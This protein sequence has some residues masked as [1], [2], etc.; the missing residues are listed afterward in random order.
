[1]AWLGLALT[2]AAASPHSSRRTGAESVL[3]LHFLGDPRGQ[4]DSRQGF[5]AALNLAYSAVH[6]Y[7]Y[8][9]VSCGDSI[10]CVVK[11]MSAAVNASHWDVIIQVGGSTCITNHRWGVRELRGAVA[12]RSRNKVGMGEWMGRD[13]VTYFVADEQPP[14]VLMGR[15]EKKG[16]EG[17][18]VVIWGRNSAS[19]KLVRSW[20]GAARVRNSS[21][22]SSLTDS[23]AVI[24]RKRETGKIQV[25]SKEWFHG[26][27]PSVGFFATKLEEETEWRQVI[28]SVNSLREEDGHAIIQSFHHLMSSGRC[29]EEVRTPSSL[30]PVS[31]VAPVLAWTCQFPPPPLPLPEFSPRLL[32]G[33]DLPTSGSWPPGGI[34]R[35]KDYDGWVKRV[36]TFYN[37][38]KE[39]CNYKSTR[40]LVGAQDCEHRDVIHSLFWGKENGLVLELGGLDGLRGPA[41][42]LPLMKLSGWKRVL[43]EGDPLYVEMRQKNSPDAVS[44]AAAVCSEPGEVHFLHGKWRVINGIGEFMNISFMHLYHPDSYKTLMELGGRNCARGDKECWA[45]VWSRVGDKIPAKFATV[46][47]CLPLHSI[48]LAALAP[49]GRVLHLDFAIIDVEGGELS[50]LAGIDWKRV[51]IGVLCVETQEMA[52]GVAVRPRGYADAV[53]AL[54]TKMSGGEYKLLWKNRG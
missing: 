3:V 11:V 18:G 40:V 22:C 21:L 12:A 49:M 43:V 35:A 39:E 31:A 44:V 9:T 10:R 50:V 27:S 34:R 51:K 32:K 33:L 7:Q 26:A 42:S 23:V 38:S 53:D 4:S 25:A 47:A 1:M 13:K 28:D 46:T 30:S 52:G 45:K 41:Q 14:A 20:Y 37:D 6:G 36:R 8:A 2:L 19:T 54:I 48:M 29:R 17:D 15:G 5:A 16:V 24:Q